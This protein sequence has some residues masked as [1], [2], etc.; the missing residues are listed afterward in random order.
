M[1]HSTFESPPADD[2]EPPKKKLRVRKG[3]KSCWECKRRKVRC[4]YSAATDTVCDEC[5]RRRSTCISQEFPDVTAPQSNRHINTGD[6][7]DRLG[8]V[9]EL[10]TAHHGKIASGLLQAWPSQGDLNLILDLPLQSS[11]R[12]LLFKVGGLLS[13]NPGVPD[14]LSLRDVLQRPPSGMHPVLIA[15]KLLLLGLLL[16]DSPTSSA[17]PLEGLT[18]DHQDLLSRAVERAVSLVTSSDQLTDSAEGIECIMMESMYHDRA[19]NLRRSWV[20]TRRAMTMAQLMGL[21]RGA[22]VRSYLNTQTSVDPE[23]LWSRIVQSDRY[24]SLMLGLPHG[25][26]ENSFATSKTLEACAPAERLRRLHCVA[27]GHILQRNDLNDLSSPQEIDGLLQRASACMPSRWWLTPDFATRAGEDDLEAPEKTLRLMS[28]AVHYHLVAQLHLPYLL[29]PSSDLSCSYRKI[30]A[31]N[32]SRE[33]LTRFIAFRK[34]NPIRSYCHGID[35]LA[36]IASTAMCIAHLDT[37][38]RKTQG[39]LG[40]DIFDFLA[41]QRQSD[42]GILEATQEAMEYM[43]V[44]GDDTVS[45]RI[46]TVLCHLLVVEDEAAAGGMC[47]YRSNSTEKDEEAGELECS[48]EMIEGDTFLKIYIP[49]LGRIMVQ[50]GG[51]LSGGP[52]CAAHKDEQHLEPSFIENWDLQ[53]VDTAFFDHLLRGLT[54]CDFAGVGHE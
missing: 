48:G 25:S 33:V 8:R 15:R 41:H 18:T 27:A 42:R 11:L 37:H 22:P 53:G 51:D 2:I 20:A 6:V 26:P 1:A 50:R 10:S 4:I 24:L 31:V 17:K 39:G 36:F 21:H 16:Q 7:E 19:G 3:T 14:E 45:Q 12:E 49:Y 28:Q 54:D 47:S 23:Y 35:F 52:A 34:G 5:E 43:A 32:A 46:A 38:R 30:T 9:E 44:N 29:R 40:N 13:A